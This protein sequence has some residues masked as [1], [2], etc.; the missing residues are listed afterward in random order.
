M[1]VFDDFRAACDKVLTPFLATHGF[2][3][4]LSLEEERLTYATVVYL[5]KHVGFELSY[6]VRDDVVDAEVV[7]VDNGVI[8]TGLHGGYSAGLF[9]YLVKHAGYRGGGRAPSPPGTP[10]MEHMVAGWVDILKAGGQTL[11]SDQ[12]NSLP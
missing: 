6:D 5:G 2:R 8:K 7:R 9:T 11:L 12:P 4:E 3:R 10:P 1:S